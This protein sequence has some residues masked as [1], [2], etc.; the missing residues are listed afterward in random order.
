M[1][2]NLRPNWNGIK[3]FYEDHFDIPQ[4]VL[5]YVAVQRILLLC[6]SGMSNK[7][8]S[9][10]L[11]MTEHYIE[12]VLNEFI[13]FGGWD[14]DLDLNPWFIYKQDIHNQSAFETKIRVLTDLI[15]NDII[16]QAY[17]VC[18]KYNYIRKQVEE[19]YEGS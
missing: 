15:K 13:D 12:D 6:A 18:S 19:Y 10:Q 11:D 4:R 8:I 7:S 9:K 3:Q 16:V 1:T 5:D 14:E 17:Y 2:R